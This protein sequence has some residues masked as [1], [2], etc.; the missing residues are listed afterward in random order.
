MGQERFDG[1]AGHVEA[2]LG[3]AVFQAVLGDGVERVEGEVGG[4]AAEGEAAALGG[5]DGGV[6]VALG[7][8]EGWGDGEGA[9]YVGDVGAEFLGSGGLVCGCW[10]VV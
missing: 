1:F 9:G 4:G 10:E 2:E 8:C 6:E 3:E 5:E 7:G